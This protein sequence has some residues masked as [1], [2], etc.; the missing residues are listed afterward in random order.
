VFEVTRAVGHD[1]PQ[2]K[3]CNRLGHRLRNLCKTRP[4]IGGLNR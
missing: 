3:P 2:T 1:A 4:P